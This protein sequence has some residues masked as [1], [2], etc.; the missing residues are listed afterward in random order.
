MTAPKTVFIDQKLDLRAFLILALLLLGNISTAS[1]TTIMGYYIVS[2]LGRDPWA[3]S[4]Y[5]LLVTAIV[6][7]LNRWF[8]SLIDQGAE[9]RRLLFASVFCFCCATLLLNIGVSFVWLL[10]LVAPLFA[11]ANSSLSVM[12]TFGRLYAEAQELNVT[13][14]NAYLR[15]STSSGWIVGP[16]ITFGLL[17][18]W[19]IKASFFAALVLGLLWIGLWSI[20]VPAEFRNTAAVADKARGS[21]GVSLKLRV[22][23]LACICFAT[24]NVLFT[25]SMPIYFIEELHLPAFAPGLSFAIKC[26]VEL[27]AIY[28]GALLAVKWGDRLVLMVAAALAVLVMFLMTTISSLS[29]LAL[30]AAL[31]GVYYGLFAGT[32]VGFMQSFADGRMGRATSIYVSS[33]FIGGMIGSISV[34]LVA[35]VFGFKGGVYLAMFSGC[36]AFVV[37]YLLKYVSE[38]PTE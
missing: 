26:L 12:Y 7:G 29:M 17:G 31:E 32:M 14:Y 38:K 4:A 23:S 33:L 34:G 6:V 9:I 36:L 3:L 22:A 30:F 28:F 13:K 24:T 21:V 10:F 2:V 5:T 16:G 25:V 18:L 1:V 37:V 11:M 35:S 20:T 27:P 19:G 8:G 15:M